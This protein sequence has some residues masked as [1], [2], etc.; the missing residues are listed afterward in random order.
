L[1]DIWIETVPF[2]ETRNYM[3]NILAYSVVYEKRLGLPI[4]R[5]RE[6]MPPIPQIPM[7]P[8]ASI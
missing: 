5:I 4:R 6:R 3:R 8:G 7:D 1:I 2:K